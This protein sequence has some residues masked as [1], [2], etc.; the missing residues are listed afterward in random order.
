LEYE[1]DLDML[2]SRNG[3]EGNEVSDRASTIRETV[4]NLLRSTTT[5]S[6]RTTTGSTSSDSNHSSHNN[7]GDSQSNLSKHHDQ[8]NET[9]EPEI[10][11]CTHPKCAQTFPSRW[12]L[13]CHLRLDHVT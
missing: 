6:R 2:S 1:E 5:I 10:L 13:V 9:T 4:L 7:L 12:A 8:M 11:P 3:D